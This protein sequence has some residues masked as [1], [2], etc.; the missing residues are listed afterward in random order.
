MMDTP[1]YL[2]AILAKSDGETLFAHTW[3]VLSRF[4]DQARLR[5]SVA[6]HIGSPRLWHRLYW[7]CLLHDFGK[8]TGG[9]QRMLLT[10]GAE[11]WAFRHEVA[12]LAFLPWLFPD[13]RNEDYRWI[14]AAIVSHHKDAD[15]INSDYKAGGPAIR[16][17]AAQLRNAPLEALWRWLDEYPAVWTTQLGLDHLGIEQPALLPAPQALVLV[18]EQG[19]AQIEQALGIYR[20]MINELTTS[21]ALRQQATVT[22]ALRGLIVNADHSASAH[23]GPSPLLTDTHYSSV[24]ARLGWQP[25]SLYAHQRL[26]AATTG[27]AVLVAPTGSGKTEAALFWAFGTEPHQLPRLFYALPFQASMNAM[28]ERL[29]A[30]FPGLVGLQ[31]GRTLQALYRVYIEDGD[32]PRFAAQRAKA[33]KNRTELNYYP[34]RVFSPYQMLKACYKLSGYEAILSDYFGAAFIF[35]E[36]HAYEPKRLALILTLVGHLRQHYQARCFIMSA[37]F[38]ELIKGVLHRTLGTYTSIDADA[39]LFAEFRRHQLH[40]L[41]GDMLASANLARIIAD[42]QAGKAVLVCC[43]TVARTQEVWTALRDR[44][45]PEATVLLLH[46]RLNGRDR[47]E[48]EKAVRTACGLNSKERRPVVLVATQVIEVSLN[49]DLDTIYTDLAPL[50]A[51]IQ[52]FGRVNRGRKQHDA[53]GNRT[54][55]PVQVFHEPIP[56][57]DLRPY[58]LRLL[59]GTLRL[60]EEQDGKPIDESTV[61]SWLNIIYGEYAEDYP[62]TWQREFDE[63]ARSFEGDVLRSLVAFNADKELERLFYAAFDSVEVLPQRFEREYFALIQDGHFVEADALLV[64]IAHWQYGMLTRQGRARPGD[65]KADDALERVNVVTATYDDDLGLL[66]DR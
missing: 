56:E 31:H 66:F 29:E 50:E 36:I 34:V 15:R 11:R 28:H 49:I 33:Q 40:L 2:A 8:A 10:N 60:L 58:D 16:E 37:T 38:P 48:R 3:Q 21:P 65:R 64:G 35:D 44:L 39:S 63:A 4:A 23:T 27:D 46:S 14:V 62:Q 1:E 47:L 24:I 41:D 30:L 12:S 22:L 59:R 20:R 7:A 42:A 25:D 18:R 5:H 61:G 55:A 43:N 13:S 17:I 6:A 32:D 45:G 51:L 53:N 54:L 26:S 52:R 9:F 19:V 57:Q